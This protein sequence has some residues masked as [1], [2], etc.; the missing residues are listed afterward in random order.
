MSDYEPE[1]EAGPQAIHPDQLADGT[2]VIVSGVRRRVSREEPALTLP[3]A[4]YTVIRAT[5]KDGEEADLLLAASG[6]WGTAYGHAKV[7]AT[8]DD[9]ARVGLIAGFEVLAVPR[10]VTAKAVLDR[11]VDFYQI[12]EAATFLAREFGVSA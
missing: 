7:W 11:M 6:H 9:I 8:A 5:L 2:I 4:P 1:P 10:P 12:S 3:D